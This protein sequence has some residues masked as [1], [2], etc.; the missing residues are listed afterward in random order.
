MVHT[1]LTSAADQLDPEPIR[2]YRRSRVVQDTLLIELEPGGPELTPPHGGF[3]LT[4]DE[5]TIMYVQVDEVWRLATVTVSG[6][7][8]GSHPG[9]AVIHA[10]GRRIVEF[11]YPS[12]LVAHPWLDKLVRDHHPDRPNPA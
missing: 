3:T 12:E 4:I 10:G 8:T 5:I 9:E 1:G 6:P 7:P 2:L 11:R